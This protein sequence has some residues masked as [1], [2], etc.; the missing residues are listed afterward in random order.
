V[1]LIGQMLRTGDAGGQMRFKARLAPP[2]NAFNNR[3]NFIA[4]CASPNPS[5]LRL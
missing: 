2:Q 1:L 4:R 5:P 3:C